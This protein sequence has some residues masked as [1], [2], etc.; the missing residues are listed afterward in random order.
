MKVNRSTAKGTRDL[1]WKTLPMR[2]GKTTDASQ[3]NFSFL[4]LLANFFVQ[5]QTLHDD[6]CLHALYIHIL[7][8]ADMFSS[9]SYSCFYICILH[10]IMGH[11]VDISFNLKLM[12]LGIL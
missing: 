11:S 1:K 2:E 9:S 7:V 12:L 10:A 3:Q 6:R 5:D 4:F 8:T